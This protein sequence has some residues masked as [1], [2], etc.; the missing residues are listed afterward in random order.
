[1]PKPAP[2]PSKVVAKGTLWPAG[3][4]LATAKDRGPDEEQD[5][6]PQRK[7]LALVRSLA[8][9]AGAPWVAIASR[10]AVPGAAPPRLQLGRGR[11]IYIY[12]NI[13]NSKRLV[14]GAIIYKKCF[15]TLY[16]V[17]G[18]EE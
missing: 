2:A 10:Y 7:T 13:Y 9:M 1:M 5:V 8:A 6:S 18:V 17:K 16:N 11:Q 3:G 14:N 4:R 15:T 12:I